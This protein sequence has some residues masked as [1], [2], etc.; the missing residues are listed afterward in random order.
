[1]DSSRRTIRRRRCSRARA[2]ASTPRAERSTTK[3]LYQ[4]AQQVLAWY[5][6]AIEKGLA[7]VDREER[8]GKRS[9]A[10]AASEKLAERGANLQAKRETLKAAEQSVARIGPPAPAGAPGKNPLSPLMKK[11]GDEAK[12]RPLLYQKFRADAVAVENDLLP[13]LKELAEHAAKAAQ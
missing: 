8:A 2:T 6:Q 13:L 3:T 7:A 11:L 9:G 1:S 5:R 12:A 4:L 10:E